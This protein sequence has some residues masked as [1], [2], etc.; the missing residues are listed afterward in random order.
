M[1]SLE[2]LAVFLLSFIIGSIPSGYL[3]ARSKG[4]DIRKH[5]SGNIGATNVFRTLGKK[6][7][8]LTLLLDL[9]KGTISV[10]L[11]MGILRDIHQA[12]YIAALGAVLGHDF[13]VF[14]RFK[15][16]KGVATTYGATLPIA[17]YASFSGMIV[18][19]AVLLLTK[20]SSLAALVSFSLS[21]LVCFLLYHIEQTHYLFLFLWGLMLWKH[22]EN[23][24]RIYQKKENRLRL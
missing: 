6:E 18:W 15:G 24:K 13:S 23:I 20:Y 19:I 10:L 14:L 16:G 22:R 3:I 8:A 4:I 11:A 1:E 7:G 5:G 12:P 2:L 17:F 9:L 21:V